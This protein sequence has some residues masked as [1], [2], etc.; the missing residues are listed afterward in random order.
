MTV[1]NLV[2]KGGVH[3]KTTLVVFPPS[4]RGHRIWVDGTM[5]TAGEKPTMLKCGHR[6]IQIGSAGKMRKVDLPCGKQI[7]LD[8]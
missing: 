8:E 3:P 7:V 5:V 6:K 4:A 1:D 2:P